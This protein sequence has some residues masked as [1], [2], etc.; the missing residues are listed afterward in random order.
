MVMDVLSLV[1]PHFVP[2]LDAAT[3]A[4]AAAACRDLRS[5]CQGQTVLAAAAAEAEA[6]AERQAAAA[7]AEDDDLNNFIQLAAAAVA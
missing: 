1:F 5:P 3:A 2:C 4:A 7:A 6:E